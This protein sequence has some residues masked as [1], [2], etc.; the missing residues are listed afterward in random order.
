MI[1]RT[2]IVFVAVLV[3]FGV[4]QGLAFARWPEL[5]KTSVPSFL[6]P[7][8]LSLAIDVAIRPAVAAGKLTDLRTETRFAGLLGSVLAFMAVRWAVPTL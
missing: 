1:N 6:W 5:E 3:A 4:L 7:L 8:I 2:S